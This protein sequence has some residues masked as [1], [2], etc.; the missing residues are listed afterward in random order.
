MAALHHDASLLLA[1]SARGKRFLSIRCR[2][3]LAAFVKQKR[4]CFLHEASVSGEGATQALDSRSPASAKQQ[5]AQT[6]SILVVHLH[7]LDSR[8]PFRRVPM[9]GPVWLRGEVL[10]QATRTAVFSG[11]AACLSCMT[12]SLS[13]LR[14]SSV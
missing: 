8:A 10:S 11:A 13:W 9:D 1:G 7:E 2:C 4:G 14:L 5:R 6:D 3:V 12:F